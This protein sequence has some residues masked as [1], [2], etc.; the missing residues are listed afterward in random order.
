LKSYAIPVNPAYNSGPSHYLVPEDYATIYN[1]APLYQAGID[2]TGQSIAIV[3]QS[4]I[5]MSDI[6]AFRTR[7]NLKGIPE[8]VRR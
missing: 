4:N 5:L 3:G 6:R 1:I 7:Y 2:G 8:A